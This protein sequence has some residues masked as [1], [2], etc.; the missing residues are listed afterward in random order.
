MKGEQSCQFSFLGQ[1]KYSLSKRRENYEILPDNAHLEEYI[2]ESLDFNMAS[3]HFGS[4]SSLSDQHFGELKLDLDCYFAQAGL[5]LNNVT[6]HPQKYCL[7]DR[8]NPER[9]EVCRN[10]RYTFLIQWP[11]GGFTS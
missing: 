8:W 10:F 9:G 6:V 2:Y 4:K 1:V 11:I 5:I 7:K 3:H